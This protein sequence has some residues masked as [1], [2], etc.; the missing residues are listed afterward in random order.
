M[1]RW[2]GLRRYLAQHGQ[3]GVFS[4]G[5]GNFRT[6]SEKSS[7]GGRHLSL[8]R[9]SWRVDNRAGPK[10]REGSQLRGPDHHVTSAL[11]GT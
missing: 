11:S 10:G 3:H 2:L 6:E 7:W 4:R 8:I 9:V 1:G 5:Y